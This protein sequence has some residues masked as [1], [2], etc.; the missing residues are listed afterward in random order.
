MRGTILIIEPGKTSSK[1]CAEINGEPTLDKLKEAI[2][3]GYIE[4]VPGF[5]SVVIDNRKRKCVAFGDEDG[6]SKGM[7]VNAA[8]TGLWHHALL[9]RGHP[10][11]VVAAT[12][13]IADFL[14]G[15]IALVYGDDEFMRSL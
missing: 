5:D 10:G 6:K 7:M 1:K 3:G 8:A 13:E 2:G 14:V 9:A 4:R 12:G 11:L 15:P